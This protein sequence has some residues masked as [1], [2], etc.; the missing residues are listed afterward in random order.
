MIMRTEGTYLKIVKKSNE[1]SLKLH[2]RAHYET[3]ICVKKLKVTIAK[4][5]EVMQV[6]ML[7]HFESHRKKMKGLKKKT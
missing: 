6:G 7:E 4:E 1:E 5:E 2:L 3:K